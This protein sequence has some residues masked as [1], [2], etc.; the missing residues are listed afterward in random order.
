MRQPPTSASGATRPTADSSLAGARTGPS[1]GQGRLVSS[2][3]GGLANGS[4]RFLELIDM[5]P[6][7]LN[8]VEAHSGAQFVYDVDGNHHQSLAH[9][10]QARRLLRAPSPTPQASKRENSRSGLVL[11]AWVNACMMAARLAG[12]ID[13]VQRHG[14]PAERQLSVLVNATASPSEPTMHGLP[15]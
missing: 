1:D 8:C 10:C 4:H 9:T 14:K 12:A 15:T 13:M 11:Q 7:N 5:R 3:L 6:T 2:R